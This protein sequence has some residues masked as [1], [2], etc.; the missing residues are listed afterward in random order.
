MNTCEPNSLSGISV[1]LRGGWRRWRWR[2]KLKTKTLMKQDPHSRSVRSTT[3]SK[4]NPENASSSIQDLVP[5]CTQLKGFMD[6]QAKINKD[7]VT[8]FEGMEII[9]EDLDGKVTEVIILSMKCSS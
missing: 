6:E 3:M 4:V 7:V 8:K 1:Y 2:K 5:L 9:L